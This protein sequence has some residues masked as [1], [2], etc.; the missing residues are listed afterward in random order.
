MLHNLFI[1]S[2][3]NNAFCPNSGPPIVLPSTPQVVN[4]KSWADANSKK[5]K[6]KKEKQKRGRDVDPKLKPEDTKRTK[7]DKSPSA[8]STGN[9]F[10][11]LLL[12]ST[13]LTPLRNKMHRIA[14]E[15]GLKHVSNESVALMMAALEVRLL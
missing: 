7:Y 14:N 2:I 10:V 6:E 11:T 8:I 9:T 3:V 15:N 1:K 13:Q 4:V 5:K 12:S